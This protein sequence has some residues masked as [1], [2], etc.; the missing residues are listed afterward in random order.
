MKEMKFQ[1]HPYKPAGVAIGSCNLTIDKFIRYE[2]LS[3]QSY[4][5]CIQKLCILV[6][7]LKPARHYIEL[8]YCKRNSRSSLR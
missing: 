6:N 7:I 5:Y 1:K 3:E 8:H 2:L 4:T